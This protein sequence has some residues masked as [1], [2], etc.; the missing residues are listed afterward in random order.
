MAIKWLEAI[1][2]RD[3]KVLI[4]KLRGMN[5]LIPRMEWCF[6]YSEMT[7][8]E[9]PRFAIR[10]MVKDSLGLEAGS[11]KFIAKVI[12][13]ECSKIEKYVYLI[14]PT[15]GILSSSKNF[16][17]HMWVRPTQILRF[18]TTSINKEVMDLLRKIEE[19]GMN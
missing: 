6:P 16:C 14:E 17:E 12:P 7:E 15:S 3:G 9:S 2:Y 5:Q 13:S 18:F 4:S 11:T 10:K 8:V 19:Q 1:V